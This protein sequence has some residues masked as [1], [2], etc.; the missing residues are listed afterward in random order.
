MNFAGIGGTG[1]ERLEVQRSC[2]SRAYCS[3]H[4]CRLA[5]GAEVG[6]LLSCRGAV[7]KQ[8]LDIHDGPLR[9]GKR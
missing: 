2:G 4:L 8:P 1:G 5:G 6:Q 9:L 3:Q 7:E